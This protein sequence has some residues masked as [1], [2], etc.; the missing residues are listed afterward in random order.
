METR[1][2]GEGDRRESSR[3]DETGMESDG[4]EIDKGEAPLLSG[5]KEQIRHY[6]TRINVFRQGGLLELQLTN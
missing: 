6:L 5:R 4:R 1:N 3:D 2:K